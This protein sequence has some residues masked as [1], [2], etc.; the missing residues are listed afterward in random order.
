VPGW[1]NELRAWFE[2]QKEGSNVEG[3]LL[4][5]VGCRLVGDMPAT[6]RVISGELDQVTTA[7]DI[8]KMLSGASISSENHVCILGCGHVP[9][10]NFLKFSL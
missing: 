8:T 2:S 10:G 7:D 1:E 5:S 9:H 6:V 4:E 3:K